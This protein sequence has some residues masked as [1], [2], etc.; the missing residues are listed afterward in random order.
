MILWDQEGE[1]NQGLEKKERVGK[2]LLRAP[3]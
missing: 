2:I 1:K 3:G